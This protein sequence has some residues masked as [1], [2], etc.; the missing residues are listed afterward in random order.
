MEKPVQQDVPK[1]KPPL[2][3]AWWMWYALV[4]LWLLALIFLFQWF[5]VSFS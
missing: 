4:I 3:P 2:F 5:T 1:E